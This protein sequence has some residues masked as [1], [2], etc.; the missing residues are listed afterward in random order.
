MK[1]PCLAMRE[2]TERP[3]TTEIDTNCLVGRD[4]KKIMALVRAILEN[5]Y[6]KGLIPA[7]CDGKASLRVVSTIN[8]IPQ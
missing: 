7:K 4:I 2:N 6:K 8:R 5:R 3:A 1:I